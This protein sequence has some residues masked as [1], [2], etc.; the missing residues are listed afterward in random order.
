MGLQVP[1]TT[2]QRGDNLRVDDYR[3]E[4]RMRT[5]ASHAGEGHQ[6]V[7]LLRVIPMLSF[8]GDTNSF[9]S[10][11]PFCKLCSHRKVKVE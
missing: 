4:Q 6:G 9:L 2:L 10:N 7:S 8:E 11:H 1:P 5:W 3:L